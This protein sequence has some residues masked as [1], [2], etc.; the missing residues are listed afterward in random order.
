MEG[1][2]GI[3]SLREEFHLRK[4]GFKYSNPEHFYSCQWRWPAWVYILIR[5]FL[6]VYTIG[7]LITIWAMEPSYT[8][9]RFLTIWTYFMLTLH[10]IVA[11]IIAIF[12]Q[13]QRS[14]TDTSIKEEH[15]CDYKSRENLGYVAEENPKP[16][17]DQNIGS[18]KCG[19]E[20]NDNI[21]WYMKLSW[22]LSDIVHVFSIIVTTIYFGAIY[23]TLTVTESQLF[24]DL[25]MHA[26]NT[27]FVL[28]DIAIS[29]RPVRFLHFLYPIIY[30]LVYTAF[31]LVLYGASGTVIY[32][33][34]DYSQPLYPSITVP[35]LC[36]I[37]IPLL[38]LV[39]FGI[40]LLKHY[41]F[42]KVYFE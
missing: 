10:L 8:I 3:G 40:Y 19:N 39:F 7:A 38:Q 36:F 11:A 18:K 5:V 2:G 32:N 35:G 20:L 6:S 42:C 29:A 9:L 34:L 16:T 23:P 33:V 37:V 14:K 15:E 4:L 22:L 30:G 17:E 25:N 31:S 13:F 27:V 28:I 41:I 1:A 21:T 12:H 26:F 24:N